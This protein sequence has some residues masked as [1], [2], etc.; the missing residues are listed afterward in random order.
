MTID[1]GLKPKR[2][3]ALPRSWRPLDVVPDRHIRVKQ[4]AVMAMFPVR[5]RPL[6]CSSPGKRRYLCGQA[7]RMAGSSAGRRGVSPEGTRA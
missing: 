5:W 3:R 1:A 4:M 2:R 7:D 6:E